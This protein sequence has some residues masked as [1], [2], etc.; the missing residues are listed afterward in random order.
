MDNIFTARLE[1]IEKSLSKALSMDFTRDW[2]DASFGNLSQSVKKEHIRAL[3]EP[4]K[5]LIDLGGKRW[6]PLFLILC[7]EAAASKNKETALTEQQAYDLTSLVEFAHT[8]SLI[9]DDI[10]DSADFRR[11][12]PAAHIKYGTDTAIN[13]ADWLYLQAP[14]CIDTLNTAADIKLTFYE[15]YSKE[16]RKLLLGQAMDIKWHSD[17]DFYPKIEAYNA[18]VKCKTGTL[19]SLACQ[20]GLIA[21]G[22]SKEIAWRFGEVAANIGIGFQIIDDILNLTKGNPGKKRGD[23]I[24]EGKKSLPVLLH[25][26]NHPQDKSKISELFNQARK[27]GIESNAV[28]ECIALLSRSGC[29]EQAAAL[30][31]Q[32]IKENCSLFETSPLISQLFLSMLPKDL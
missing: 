26:K 7:Y 6:R 21:G 16:M 20:I 4:N 27:E 11:G 24:V 31:E 30:G 19:A 32:L 15:L 14:V 5:A 8:A 23:D 1:K 13:S 18:M 28:E 17:T 25:I 22:E 12:Q 2:Q 9:H 3:I 29:I 10:E